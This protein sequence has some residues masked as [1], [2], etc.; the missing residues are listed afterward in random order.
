MN[1]EDIQDSVRVGNEVSVILRTGHQ[2]SGVLSEIRETSIMLRKASGAKIP[3]SAEAID[4]IFPIE[5]ASSSSSGEIT[6]G[7]Q[8]VDTASVLPASP[9]ILSGR[10]NHPEPQPASPGSDK[11]T[12]LGSK[13]NPEQKN[14]SYSVEVLTKV[15]EIS[16]ELLVN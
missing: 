2:F 13:Q 15:V 16:L 1:I 4:C 5:T 14:P 12:E 9:S 11:I 6:T 10:E 8:A 3:L 7:L